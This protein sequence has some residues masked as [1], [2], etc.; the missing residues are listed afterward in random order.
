M[1]EFAASAQRYRDI[2]FCPKCGCAYRPDDFDA[3]AC[4]FVCG[5]CRFDFFQNPLPAAVTVLAHPDHAD[6]VLMLR[7]RTE[8]HIGRWCLPG[9]FLTYGETAEAAAR[10]ELLEEAG[11]HA[12]IG[13]VLYV[14]LIDYSYRGR[15]LCVLELS[16]HATMRGA[17][18]ARGH[19]TAEALEIDFV[20]V[21]TLI[22]AP[23]TL[24]FPEHVQVLQAFKARLP[25]SAP[26]LAGPSVT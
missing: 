18:P 20:P 5:A 4:V 15:Q 3:E 6:R 9:G 1:H 13:A 14:G 22:K 8:P 10:R 16:F 19:V 25:I 21:D 23:D 7:R 12:D 11:F 24:A 2:R 17:L 26:T